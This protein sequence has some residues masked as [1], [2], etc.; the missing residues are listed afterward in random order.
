MDNEIREA[1]YPFPGHI[2]S[3]LFKN[4]AFSALFRLHVFMLPTFTGAGSLT[5]IRRAAS[6][7][8]GDRV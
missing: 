4:G 8:L 2:L 7:A 5:R 3:L 1:M 6:H